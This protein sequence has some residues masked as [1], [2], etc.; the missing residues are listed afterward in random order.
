MRYHLLFFPWIG[1]VIGG[2][3]IAW[4]HLAGYLGV[5]K[6]LSVALAVFLPLFVTGGFHMDGFMDTKDAL[7][8]YHGKEKKLEIL[9]RSSYRCLCRY[10]LAIISLAC[11]WIC[12]CH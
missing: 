12:F 11:P 6:I 5:G 10:P 4:Y 3:E 2:L 8:S 7:S 9:K 1:A